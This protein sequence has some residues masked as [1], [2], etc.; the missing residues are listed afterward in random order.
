MLHA[1]FVLDA[2]SHAAVAAGTIPFYRDVE[3]KGAELMK[4]RPLLMG[5]VLGA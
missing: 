2:R 5:Q 1:I 3:E 4:Q